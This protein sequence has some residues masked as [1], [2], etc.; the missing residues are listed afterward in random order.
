MGASSYDLYLE[1]LAR[2]R[3]PAMDAAGALIERGEYA[4][5]IAGVKKVDDSIYAD[6][7]LAKLLEAHLRTLVAAHPKPDAARLRIAFD[8]ALDI[9]QRAYPEPH[10]QY[11]ADD[12]ATGRAED[13]AR[14]VNILGYDPAD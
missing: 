13:R 14:L 5:A 4:E 7:A 9:A 1:Q 3:A 6:V 12:Y 10:T 2:K 8:H 11:E